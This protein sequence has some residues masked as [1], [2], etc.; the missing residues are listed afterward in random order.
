M[1]RGISRLSIQ[2][3]IQRQ[4]VLRGTSLPLRGMRDDQGYGI[5]ARAAIEGTLDAEAWV[6]CML[7]QSGADNGYRIIA[8]MT[9]DGVPS[10]LPACPNCLFRLI[11]QITSKA[12][13]PSCSA[14]ISHPPSPFKFLSNSRQ[15]DKKRN[16]QSRMA[17]P[18]VSSVLASPWEKTRSSGG[19][20]VDLEWE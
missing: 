19:R 15:T 17:I 4:G 9:V 13:H 14:P 5:F 20:A 8:S 16:L 18:Q 10:P 1:P 11:I 7:P 2:Q 3:A 6:R 12:A